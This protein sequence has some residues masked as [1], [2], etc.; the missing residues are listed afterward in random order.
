MIEKA[1]NFIRTR[2]SSGPGGSS[3][4]DAVSGGEL[5]PPFN[6]P[7]VEMEAIYPGHPAYPDD[8]E[9][10]YGQP[11]GPCYYRNDLG[12]QAGGTDNN[13]YTDDPDSPTGS[14]CEFLPSSFNCS[15]FELTDFD[16]PQGDQITGNCRTG[17]GV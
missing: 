16:I 6:I 10:E 13:C 4:T 14:L 7:C 5:R 8:C 12:E 2:Y 3:L 1:L 17:Y 11:C 9:D 15:D